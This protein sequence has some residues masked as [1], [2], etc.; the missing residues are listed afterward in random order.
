M[1]I[2]FSEKAKHH[3]E[4]NGGNVYLTIENYGSTGGCCNPGDVQ[5]YLPKISTQSDEESQKFENYSES[6]FRV[7]FHPLLSDKDIQVDAVK[8]LGLWKLEITNDL[9]FLKK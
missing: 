6:G 9:A 2:I 5:S 7:Y 1:A 8:F 4:K 3:I